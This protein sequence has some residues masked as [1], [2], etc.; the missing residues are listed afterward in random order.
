MTTL[1]Q[2]IRQLHLH[3]PIRPE[4]FHVDELRVA[5]VLEIVAERFSYVA[6]IA[7]MK[8]WRSPPRARC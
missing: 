7:G 8:V 5:G 2:S 6:D 4:Y 1:P 3:K